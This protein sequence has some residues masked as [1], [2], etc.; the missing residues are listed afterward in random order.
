MHTVLVILGGLVLMAVI[1]GVAFWRGA[2]LRRAFPLFAVLWV[3]TAAINLWVGV[4]HAGYGV[5][6]E[7]PIFAV[8]FGIP[9][10]VAWLLAR[11]SA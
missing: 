11:Q 9:C 1:Y 7:L 6:E 3:A 10:V 5:A 4:A 2:S 8:V